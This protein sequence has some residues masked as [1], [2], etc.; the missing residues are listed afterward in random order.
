MVVI[1]VVERVF[2]FEEGTSYFAV[3]S[4]VPVY[5]GT[6]FSYKVTKLNEVTDY[7]FRIFASNDAGSGPYSDVYVYTTTKA[8]PPATKGTPILLF[9]PYFT[10]WC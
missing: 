5:Q 3:S 6:V 1:L 2:P 8:P 9:W 4:F 7:S 10:P